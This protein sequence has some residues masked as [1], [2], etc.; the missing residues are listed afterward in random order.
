M[1]HL[2][3]LKSSSRALAQNNLATMCTKTDSLCTRRFKICR[4]SLNWSSLQL[5]MKRHIRLNNLRLRTITKGSRSMQSRKKCSRRQQTYRQF[6][7]NGAP[8]KVIIIRTR[9]RSIGARCARRSNH[10]S[11]WPRT[12]TQRFSRRLSRRPQSTKCSSS[13]LAL[14]D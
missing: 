10:Q 12:R 11:L 4:S 9:T 3:L 13:I 2:L 5:T 14:Q 7:K 1:R 6:S 8:P